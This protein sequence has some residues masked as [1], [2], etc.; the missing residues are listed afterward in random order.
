ME[1]INKNHIID[2]NYLHNLFDYKDGILYWKI[3][4]GRAK[5]GSEA[6]CLSKGR[7]LI[8]LNQKIY[9]VHR[10]IFCYHNGFL[11]N[12]DIDH[13][14]CNPLNNKIENLRIASDSE[15]RFNTKKY[16]INTSGY[17]NIN[18]DK[19]RNKWEVKINVNNKK[20]FLG[21]YDDIEL[22][23]LVAIMAREKYHKQFANHG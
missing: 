19:S 4:K 18:W 5:K 23:D 16:K 7:K 21:R 15:N 20:I 8:K 9:G 1:L 3:N 11:P 13:I 6:G 12:S 17:K 10:I 2:K 22:A 14:D